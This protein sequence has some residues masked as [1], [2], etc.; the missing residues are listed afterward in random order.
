MRNECEPFALAPRRV[1]V[2]RQPLHA[3]RVTF[4]DSETLPGGGVR[5]VQKTLTVYEGE[6]NVPPPPAARRCS[7]ALVAHD[8]DVG[9]AVVGEDAQGQEARLSF[10]LGDFVSDGSVRELTRAFSAR[11]AL[12]LNLNALPFT[13]L[14]RGVPAVV[15][16]NLRNDLG[17]FT[18]PRLTLAVPV[19]GSLFGQHR[20]V[21]QLSLLGGRP[22]ITALGVT[23]CR[24]ATPLLHGGVLL[25]MVSTGF[26]FH[27]DGT[28]DPQVR[29]HFTL[30]NDFPV[31]T[32]RVTGS[33]VS[34]GLAS[35]LVDNLPTPLNLLPWKPSV[36]S[37][38]V[39]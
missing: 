30:Q 12:I 29:F 38:P 37:V 34:T 35:Y 5:F 27:P 32:Y 6:F 3:H 14:R 39:N 9:G 1:E 24:G 15:S 8:F 13:E 33:A 7:A 4:F 22:C 10:K 26:G 36:R 21:A 25:D 20:S 2:V 17:G 31:G 28:R 23:R 16:L 11:T 18:D 19:T